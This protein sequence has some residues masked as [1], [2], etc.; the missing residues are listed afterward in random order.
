MQK[1]LDGMKSNEP[2]VS[3]VVI[4]ARARYMQNRAA[5]FRYAREL[6][7]LEDDPIQPMN[8]PEQYPCYALVGHLIPTDGRHC[9][10]WM[11]FYYVATE[12]APEKK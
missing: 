10:A 3:L 9:R 5:W 8:Y 1:S 4:P 11:Q 12:D 7:A 6:A 2:I